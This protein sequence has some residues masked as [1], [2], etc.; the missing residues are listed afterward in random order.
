M[1]GFDLSAVGGV[2]VPRFTSILSTL[3][4]KA[5]SDVFD[6]YYRFGRCNSKSKTRFMEICSTGVYELLEASREK[7]ERKETKRADAVKV[8]DLVI[9]CNDT[10]NHINSDELRRADRAVSIKR[11]GKTVSLTSIFQLSFNSDPFTGKTVCVGYGDI[12]N[13]DARGA[14]AVVFVIHD[15][16]IMEGGYISPNAEIEMFVSR[17]RA[18]N[19]GRIAQMVAKGGLRKEMDALR[20]AAKPYGVG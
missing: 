9:Y 6:Y 17:G 3:G 12:P 4:V 13:N 10:R 1:R 11:N 20:M 14:D 7:N 16:A 15:M 2:D 18:C 8:G 5:R 19:A